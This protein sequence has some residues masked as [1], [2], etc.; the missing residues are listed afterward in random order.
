MR[1]WN[2]PVNA[3]RTCPN[4]SLSIR[5]SGSA[6]Q[7]TAT[8]GPSR[9]L[10]AMCRE[11]APS[12]LPVPVSPVI[13]T[14]ARRPATSRMMCRSCRIS[15]LPPTSIRE[16]S[17]L[18][19]QPL[20]DAFEFHPRPT[21]SWRCHLNAGDIDAALRLHIAREVYRV[22]RVLFQSAEVLIIDR[23]YV[24]PCHKLV[25]RSEEHTS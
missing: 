16:F 3:P 1:F 7:F 14:V 20:F 12:S 8:I 18:L 13:N 15:R 25:L 24:P 19:A 22:T 11:S 23:V 2:A 10:P 21:S 4:S 9:R 17:L 5:L 6:L